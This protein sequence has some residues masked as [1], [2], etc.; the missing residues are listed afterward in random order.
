MTILYINLLDGADVSIVGLCRR[1]CWGVRSTMGPPAPALSLSQCANSPFGCSALGCEVLLA[2]ALGL[3][4]NCMRQG[5]VD[6]IRFILDV[7]SWRGLHLACANGHAGLVQLLLSRG[8]TNVASN[9]SG[10]PRLNKFKV[11]KEELNKNQCLNPE[12]RAVEYKLYNKE[13]RR[14]CKGLDKVEHA[15]NE[16]A[17]MLN[18]PWVLCIG[19]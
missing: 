18:C 1:H 19:L 10:N 7:W 6:D 5:E 16:E 8:T 11:E 12:R 3:L 15:R 9:G 4:Y 13:L 2:D 14:V 17:D